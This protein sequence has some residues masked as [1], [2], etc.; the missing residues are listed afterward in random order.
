VPKAATTRREL[1]FEPPDTLRRGAATTQCGET[2]YRLLRHLDASPVGATTVA[3]ARVAVW[4][5]TRGAAVGRS[6]VKSL[7]HR[8]NLVLEGIGASVR[9]SLDG[10]AVLLL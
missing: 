7:V 2:V 9:V 3:A 6:T 5:R 10:E 1:G 4:G 8:T